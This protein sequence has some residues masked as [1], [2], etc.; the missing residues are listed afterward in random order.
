MRHAVIF[1]AGVLGAGRHHADHSERLGIQHD[2]PPEDGG[3]GPK[4]VTPQPVAEDDLRGA[5]RNF[6]F[7]REFMAAR[8][9]QAERMEETGGDLKARK[10]L[11]LSAAG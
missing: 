10:A 11:R 5:A 2:L 8:G 7:A 3:V 6:I 9:T 1:V 4:T